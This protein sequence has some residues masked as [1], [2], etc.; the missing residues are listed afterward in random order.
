M[1]KE[2]SALPNFFPPSYGFAA[3]VDPLENPI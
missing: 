2:H 1:N 3:E